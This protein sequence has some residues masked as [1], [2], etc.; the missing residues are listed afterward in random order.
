MLK[1]KYIYKNDILYK[2]F[3]EM[4]VFSPN[5]KD[6]LGAFKMPYYT[7]WCHSYEKCPLLEIEV[8]TIDF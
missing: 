8:I 3:P 4:F 2:K 1:K 6:V 5:Q 7:C